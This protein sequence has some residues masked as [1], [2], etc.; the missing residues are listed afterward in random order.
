MRVLQI[1]SD[2]FPEKQRGGLERFYYDFTRVL[3]EM[4]TGVDG[5]IT[6][7]PEVAWQTNG[8][9]HGFAPMNAPI[10]KRLIAVRRQASS[11]ISQH[12]YSLVASHFVLYTFPVLDKIRDLPLVMHFHG[13][14]SLE[15]G[16]ESGKVL[17]ISIRKFMERSVYGQTVCFIVLSQAFKD[18]LHKRYQVPLDK[19]KIVPGGVDLQQFKSILSTHDARSQLGWPSDRRILFTARRL[20]KR[21]GLENLIEA[22]KIVTRQYADVQ[23]YI[24]GKGDMAP[25]LA[26]QIKE[27]ELSDQVHLVGYMSDADLAIAYRAADLTVIPTLT[28]E[29]FGMIVL[30]SLAAGTP[31][32]GTPVGGIPEILR[33]FSADLVF[34]GPTAQHIA[35]GLLDVFSGDRCLPDAAT[36]EAYVRD[37][38]TWTHIAGRISEIYQNVLDST[39]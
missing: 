9:F 3:A 27:L 38:F 13:P 28:L 35:Q 37:N 16:V 5:L 10:L 15:S 36:C 18:L 8:R 2:W 20:S 32:L 1:G 23:L 14:W 30:E 7:S 34:E 19:I 29:G 21:M 24:A 12:N 31:V 25:F 33:P 26:Q 39:A 11:L 6:G 17:D 22:M 4:G